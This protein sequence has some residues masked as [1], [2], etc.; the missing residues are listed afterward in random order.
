MDLAHLRTWSIFHIS[1]FITFLVSSFIINIL[2]AFLYVTI[3]PI[4]KS[5]YHRVNSFLVWQ[6]HAQPLFVGTWWSNSCV[7]MH[8]NDE[9]LKDV[10]GRKALFLMNHHY[11]IDWLFA[12]MC[13]DAFGILGNGRVIAKKMLKFVPT[14]G[15]AWALSDFIFVE[16]DWEKDKLTMT[17]GVEELASYPSSVWLLLY[18]EGTRI[19]P[20][21]LEASQ[22]YAKAKNLPILK[23]HL[24]P[25]S[26]G[27][28][29][30]IKHLDTSKVKY[31]Y[32]ATLG[33][34]PSDGATLATLA[35]VLMGKRIVGDVYLR[36]FNTVDISKDDEGAHDFLMQVYKDKDVLLDSYKQT[37]GRSFTECNDFPHVQS[38]ELPRKIGVLI[39]T[40]ILSLMICIPLAYKT[41]LMALSGDNI[42]IFTALFIILVLFAMK[43]AMQKFIDITRIDK[44]SQYGHRKKE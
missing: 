23:H 4:N 16:R 40:V 15:W 33:I 34:H 42:Q 43:F 13:A 10:R 14:V 31:V 12:W 32:D 2:Q 7:R 6:I 25:R 5:L 3:R 19:N 37:G 41:C 38:V 44:A 28:V 29:H 36:R 18:A 17:G 26:K 27:F 20:E 11:D 9:V 24:T 35:T 30:I 21:K 39:N 22:K 8:C 1:I